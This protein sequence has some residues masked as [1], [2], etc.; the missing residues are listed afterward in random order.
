M[1]SVAL[2]MS[3]FLVS[4]IA[5]CALIVCP[6]SADTHSCCH[7]NPPKSAPDC[8]YT[9]LEKS[10]ANPSLSQVFW[11]GFTVNAGYTAPQLVFSH[12]VTTEC[13]LVDSAGLFLRNRVLLI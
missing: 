10:K 9:I 4:A 1:R 12:P 8:P 2:A 11:T 13:R 6:A 7:Q 3:A 5:L